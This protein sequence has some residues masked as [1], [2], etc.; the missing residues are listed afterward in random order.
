[1]PHVPPSA[2]FPIDA[3]AEQG[4]CIVDGT[5]GIGKQVVSAKAESCVALQTTGWRERDLFRLLL[6]PAGLD[7]EPVAAEVLLSAS[8]GE[9][10]R[11]G[12]VTRR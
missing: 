9:G 3:P 4:C 10:E 12:L 5:P 1:M 2:A 8:T 6:H 11:F 7:A